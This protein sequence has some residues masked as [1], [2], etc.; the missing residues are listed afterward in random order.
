LY[1]CGGKIS[2]KANGLSNVKYSGTPID[3]NKYADLLPTSELLL[4]TSFNAV[5]IDELK[6]QD[7]NKKGSL[8][9][10]VII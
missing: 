8:E 9:T 3:R 10:Q 5:N 2:E 7:L 1:S 6:D 4:G